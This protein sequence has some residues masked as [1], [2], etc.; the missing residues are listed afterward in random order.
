MKFQLHDR[1]DPSVALNSLVSTVVLPFLVTPP[2]LRRGGRRYIL[3]YRDHTGSVF[4]IVL[5]TAG[6][7]GTWFWC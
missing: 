2:E 6:E 7:V 1:L 5:R 4:Y 3:V